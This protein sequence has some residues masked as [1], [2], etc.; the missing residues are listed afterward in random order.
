[1]KQDRRFTCEETLAHATDAA[2]GDLRSSWQTIFLESWDSHWRTP[3]AKHTRSG[4]PKN[5]PVRE[6]KRDLVFHQHVSANR[7]V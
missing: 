5:L 4:R 6:P 1:V 2:H 7:E 3:T